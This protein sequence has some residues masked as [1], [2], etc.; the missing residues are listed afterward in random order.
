MG[1]ICGSFRLSFNR[2][3]IPPHPRDRTRTL[4]PAQHDPQQVDTL[5]HR[6]DAKPESRP[7]TRKLFC[8]SAA[9]PGC[10]RRTEA[11]HFYRAGKR[12][13]ELPNSQP[14]RKRASGTY[15]WV[16][17]DGGGR[18]RPRSD[19]R[20]SVSPVKGLLFDGDSQPCEPTVA[21]HSTRS[22]SIAFTST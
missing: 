3:Q 1:V 19:R 17:F 10:P 6:R 2:R 9:V 14:V 22:S 4:L 15:G 18:G 7:E 11:T 8:R 13:S 16:L 21:A 5:L 20:A 12:R